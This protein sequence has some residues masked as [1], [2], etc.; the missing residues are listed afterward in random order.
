MNITINLIPMQYT[1]L[2]DRDGKEIYE[3]YILQHENGF[4]GDVA[5]IN[6]AFN[7]YPITNSSQEINNEAW[8]DFTVE[9]S[10]GHSPFTIIDNIYNNIGNYEI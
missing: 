5:Y 7:V 2:N 8:E 10:D 6:N 3:G 4:I 1:G 9:Y